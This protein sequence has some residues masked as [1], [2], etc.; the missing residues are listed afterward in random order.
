MSRELIDLNGDLKRLEDANFAV[1]IK[2]DFLLIDQIPF[3]SSDRLIK[4]G[5]LVSTL[6]M[7]DGRTV[8]PADH[9]AF[10][11]GG[12]PCKSDGSPYA[13]IIHDTNPRHLAE[14]L[15]V[16]VMFSTQPKPDGYADY[17]HKMSHLVSLIVAQAAVLDRSVTAK[18]EWKATVERTEDV[19]AYTDTNATRAG[20]YA[21]SQK[22]H[23]LKIGIVGTGGT[24]SYVLDLVAKCPVAQIHLFDG[25]QFKQ[26]NAFRAPGAASSE[27]VVAG[28]QKVDYLQGE[29]AKMHRGIHAHPYKVD[30]SN[31]HELGA[32]DFVFLCVDDG[33]ARHLVSQFC[34]EKSIPHIDVGIG[35]HVENGALLGISRVTSYSNG[36]GS[37]LQKYVDYSPAPDEEN[38]YNQNIQIAELNALNAAFAVLRWK[39]FLGYYKDTRS[40]VN[41]LYTSSGN[42]IT[43]REN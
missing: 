40:E 3:V 6:Q 30:E 41:S 37:Y 22:Y 13:E 5:C 10:F 9:T 35:V 31:L 38:A 21:L 42:F 36:D 25:D 14:G 12:V 18:C 16:E 34:I 7:V 26:H 1:I 28:A 8:R 29:Y 2:G 33:K 39:R 43:H 19:F 17:F 24:G 11:M 15:D 27:E 23:G 32:L 4:R 20:I